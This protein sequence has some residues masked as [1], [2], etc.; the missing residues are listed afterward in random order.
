VPGTIDS[1]RLTLA[2]GRGTVAPTWVVGL[3]LLEICYVTQRSVDRIAGDGDLSNA[4][5]A[6]QIDE[7]L[8]QPNTLYAL[9]V[10]AERGERVVGEAE[11]SV[12]S[13][14]SATF[15]FRTGAAPGLN[16]TT[17][18]VEAAAGLSGAER[19]AH[20][21]VDFRDGKLNELSSYVQRTTPEHG[22]PTFYG[23]YDVVVSFDVP[24]LTAL[25]DGAL[26][27]RISDQNGH[28]VVGDASRWI[29]GLLPLITPGLA[30][31]LR[32]PREQSCAH[33]AKPWSPHLPRELVC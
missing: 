17:A 19:N 5:R 11:F 18:Q 23:G 22:A 1:L 24:Y 26:T 8:L 10:V 30:A 20:L 3:A 2:S 28:V 27:L 21:A 15:Y 33:G 25:F 6:G 7:S 14:E 29:T 16:L 13:H 12:P 9:E 4:D 31:F 32:A